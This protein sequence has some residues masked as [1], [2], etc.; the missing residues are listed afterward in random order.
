MIISRS[1]Q[2]STGFV[3]AGLAAR[4]S[5]TFQGNATE[6]KRKPLAK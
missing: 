6:K 4:T 5:I 1:K 3:W 2:V